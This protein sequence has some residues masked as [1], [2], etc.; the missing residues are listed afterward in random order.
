[1]SEYRPR[2]AEYQ[3][4][5]NSYYRA[6][7]E[8]LP[9]S[10]RGVLSLPT[11]AEVGAYRCAVDRSMLA[12]L[13]GGDEAVQAARPAGF[14]GFDDLSTK[15]G[16]DGPGFAYDNEGPR[17]TV[18]LVPFELA[19]RLVTNSEFLEFVLDDGYRR[20]ELWLSLGFDTIQANGW[21]APLYW[22]VVDGEW[23][24]FT[25]RGEPL[26]DPNATVTHVSYF[27]ADAYARWAGARLPS[28]AE[29]E[30]AAARVGRCGTTLEDRAWHSRPA[31]APPDFM[32]QAFGDCW[33]WTASSY[34]PYPG[35]RLPEAPGV[36]IVVV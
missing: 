5:F 23:R 7:G 31:A 3:N 35:F 34:A 18:A 11:V 19:D 30:H 4:L 26:F 1:M 21:S 28:E 16:Y 24:E 17:H 29:W 27:E 32:A 13:E 25:L 14:F 22:R 6:I 20:P 36:R 33:E 9:R 15:I 8:P 12:L 2:V 10:E